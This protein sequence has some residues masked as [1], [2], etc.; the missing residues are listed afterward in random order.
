MGKNNRHRKYSCLYIIFDIFRGRWRGHDI[1]VDDSGDE[2]MSLRRARL[3][4]DDYWMTEPGI[5]WKASAFI[6]RFHASQHP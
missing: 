2:A 4:D 6:R 5:D 3:V 1:V